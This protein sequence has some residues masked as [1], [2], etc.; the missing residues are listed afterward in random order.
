MKR[1]RAGVIRVHE[2]SLCGSIANIVE[3][4]AAGRSVSVIRIQIGQLRQVVP[5]T[6]VYCWDLVSEGTSLAGSR[7]DVEAIPARIRCRA[8][9][10]IAEVGDLP[11]LVCRECGSTDAEIVSGEEF[12]ITSLDLAETP[13]E[14]AST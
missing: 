7:I 9:D 2:L 14:G 6:L 11:I 12:M 3:R 5:E 8:C 1:W 4:H 13:A 10:Q